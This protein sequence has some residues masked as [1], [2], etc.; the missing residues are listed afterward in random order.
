MTGARHTSSAAARASATSS[1][2]RAARSLSATASSTV[3]ELI[4]RHVGVAM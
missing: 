4:D 3:A 1:G 2:L